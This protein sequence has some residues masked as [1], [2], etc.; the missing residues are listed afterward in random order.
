MTGIYTSTVGVSDKPMPTPLDLFDH[1]PLAVARRRDGVF[2]DGF[3]AWLEANAHVYR[4]FE[5]RALR[6]AR[7]RTHYSGYTILEV[8]RHESAI[9]EL[10]GE[11]KLN[12]N[13]CAD[14]CRLFALC[15]PNHAGLFEFRA[16]KAA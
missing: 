7:F 13:Q 12:N 16:R 1:D 2:R 15:N 9:G 11:W 5:K 6:V 4:E 8:M 14:L 3:V 10:D